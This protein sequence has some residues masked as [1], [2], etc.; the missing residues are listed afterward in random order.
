MNFSSSHIQ[1]FTSFTLVMA[2]G[3]IVDSTMSNVII[4]VTLQ[5]LPSPHS[6]LKSLFHLFNQTVKQMSSLKFAAMKSSVKV[7]SLF[8]PVLFAD[9]LANGNCA[10]K[11]HCITSIF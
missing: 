2:P 6:N 3:F 4:L 9:L 7:R 10:L 1:L 8:Q 5:P 11:N